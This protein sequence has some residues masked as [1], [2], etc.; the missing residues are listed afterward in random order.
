MGWSHLK[1]IG[2]LYLG[3]GIGANDSAN[4]FGTAVATRIIPYR[5]ATILIAVFVV[6]GAVLQ[7]PAQYL[8]LDFSGEA[9][10][11][12]STEAL[13]ATLATAL[14]V[15][16][17]TWLA[18]PASTSQAAVGGLMGIAVSSAGLGGVHWDRFGAMVVCWALNP[19]LSAVVCYFFL[20]L[21]GK[22]VNRWIRTAIGRDR[23][24][25][26]GLLGFGCYGAYALGA[27]NVVVTTAA[28]FHSGT[29][30]PPT[31][32]SARWAALAGSLSIA[33]GA[34]TYSRKVMTTVGCRVTPLNPFSALCVVLT[35][36]VA[37]N[38][39][40]LLHIPIS[41]SQAVVGS[42]IGVSVYDRGGFGNLGELLKIFSGWLLTPFVACLA[43]LFLAWGAHHLH[44]VL[45]S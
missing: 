40:T 23:F 10:D 22:I 17:I 6:L 25:L 2:G 5:L 41:S 29:F 15:T 12:T 36:G 34:L 26:L 18:I 9:G 16:V 38:I 21:L 31:L 45:L 32:T 3:W 7:G 4:I 13:L 37:L 14:T 43:A 20:F 33:V 19:V 24:C 35:S 42:L 28:Y 44:I 27:N 30:G 8:S 11:T 39:F 1:I